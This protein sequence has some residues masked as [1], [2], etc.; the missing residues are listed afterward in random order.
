MAWKP[1]AAAARWARS[2]PNVCF[3]RHAG[4]GARAVESR[5]LTQVT[6]RTPTDLHPDLR[7][8]LRA[9]HD[10]CLLGDRYSLCRLAQVE[11]VYQCLGYYR[12]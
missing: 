10:D 7:Q 8:Q 2:F 3:P 6:G 11:I 1:A 12:I 4:V 9:D 5:V